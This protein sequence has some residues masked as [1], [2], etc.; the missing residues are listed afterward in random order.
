MPALLVASAAPV[1]KTF[2]GAALRVVAAAPSLDHSDL[3]ADFAVLREV[4]ETWGEAD[5]LAFGEALWDL[6][7]QR[8]EARDDDAPG[9]CDQVHLRHH[10][11]GDYGRAA[12]LVAV[13][14]RKAVTA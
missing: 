6:Y 9:L 8:W 10:Q 11:V 2:S 12:R 5:L 4:R 1:S 3:A 14:L 13:K 7:R